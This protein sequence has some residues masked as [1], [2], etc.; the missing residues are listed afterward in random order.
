MNISS[1]FSKLFSI[2]L[3]LASAA[4][5]ADCQQA[6]AQTNASDNVIL[7]APLFEYPVAPDDITDLEGKSNWLMEHFWDKFDFKSKKTVDQNALN[8]AFGVYANPMR[9]A[10]RDVV[11]KATA[12]LIENI[13]KNPAMLL[14]F[15]KAAEENLY[16]PRAEAYI[17]EIYIEYL[18]ALDKNKKISDSRKVRYRRQLKILENSLIGKTAPVFE[19]TTPDGAT[20]KFMPGLLTVIEFG[21]PDCTDCAYA[22]I[23]MNSDVKFSGA[24]EKG[25]INVLFIYPDPDEG[26]QEALKNYPSLW[27]VGASDTVS[28]IYDIRQT[29][30]FFVTDTDG[31][32]VLKTADVNSAM[33]AALENM[34]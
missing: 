6:C 2:S 12:R 25:K 22:K 28:D 5:V 11:Y 29:P 14:Q 15:T 4:G 17:D 20:E 13:S 16:G 32:I 10:D 27:H 30:Y 9:W 3:I 19:F 31:K 21:D 1:Y 34:K 8:H 26:W 33:A 24:V 23:K 7:V 18:K